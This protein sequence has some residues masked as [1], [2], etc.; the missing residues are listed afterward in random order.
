MTKVEEDKRTQR[1]MIE[2]RW[3]GDDD[4]LDYL[5]FADWTE[6]EVSEAKALL[7]DAE[8]R[9]RILPGWY[10]GPYGSPN[11][12]ELASLHAL[13]DRDEFDLPDADKEDAN[14]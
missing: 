6:A 10:V 8:K 7:A 14:G 5:S 13:L 4:D 12:A 1:V 9:E 2:F 11:K 3:P